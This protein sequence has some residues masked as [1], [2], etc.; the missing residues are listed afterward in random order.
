MI[1][2]I[3]RNTHRC[4]ILINRHLIQ[5]EIISQPQKVFLYGGRLLAWVCHKF[6][7]GNYRAVYIKKVRYY[8]RYRTFL[9]DDVKSSVT[10]RVPKPKWAIFRTKHSGAGVDGERLYVYSAWRTR[11]VFVF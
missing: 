1:S 3:I 2:K 4:K 9:Y 5:Q 7:A 6:V 10:L 8:K 11:G